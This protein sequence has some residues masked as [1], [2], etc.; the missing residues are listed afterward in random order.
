MIILGFVMALF[1][2]HMVGVEVGFFTGICVFFTL[3]CSMVDSLRIKD[4]EKRLENLE[5]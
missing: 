5:K 3:L 2:G 4:V 1:A